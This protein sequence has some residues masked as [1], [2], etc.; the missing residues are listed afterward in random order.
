MSDYLSMKGITKTYQAYGREVR[1]LTSPFAAAPYT[2]CWA[3]TAQ[4]NPPL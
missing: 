1:A 2:V 3:K 4:V